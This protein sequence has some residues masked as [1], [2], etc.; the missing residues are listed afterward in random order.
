VRETVMTA[1]GGAGLTPR[2]SHESV[3]VRMTINAQPAQS[4]NSNI[5]CVFCQYLI[6]RPN[7]SLSPLSYSD[8]DKIH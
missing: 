1:V 6:K 2:H 4:V 8:C 5:M 7:S 3:I